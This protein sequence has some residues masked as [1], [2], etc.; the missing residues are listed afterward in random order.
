MSAA[1]AEL[2]PDAITL[3]VVVPVFRSA[4]TLPE[5]IERL[6][7]VLDALGQPWE[8]IFVD[9]G[10]PDESWAL[11]RRFSALDRRLV[12]IRLQRN[13]GQHAALIC[14]FRAAR[15]TVIVTLDDDL[16]HPP[17][18]IPRLWRRL[19][20]EGWDVVYGSYRVKQHAA[21]RNGASRI[22]NALYR[23]T[24][25]LPVN[26]TSFRAM[27]RK[28]LDQALAL[29]DR[30]LFMDVLMARLTD[31]IGQVPVDHQPRQRG[32]SGYTVGRLAWLSIR[33]LTDYS[34]LPLRVAVA[35]ALGLAVGGTVLAGGA[36]V[37]SADPRGNAWS[38]L[39]ASLVLLGLTQIIGLLVL[40]QYLARLHA[41]SHPQPRYLVLEVLA[42]PGWNRDLADPPSDRRQPSREPLARR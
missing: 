26:V 36:F 11:L 31:G 27:R 24:L 32:R 18:E 22:V 34:L 5:L 41:Q 4:A 21:W 37:F 42:P 28:L 25:S 15:G 1:P 8:M 38:W 10:S 2:D 23:A 13:F 14:G 30:T 20:D 16:Q 17:E 7:R 39:V 3:S 35:A 19:V 9:D 33:L 40:A 29:P 12:A 6:K